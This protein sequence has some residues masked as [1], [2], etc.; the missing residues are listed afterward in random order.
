MKRGGW[1]CQKKKFFKGCLGSPSVVEESHGHWGGGGGVVAGR[2]R[3][4]AHFGV[5]EIKGELKRLSAPGRCQ[6]AAVGIGG[7]EGRGRLGQWPGVPQGPCLGFR[8]CPRHPHTAP[9]LQ[10]ESPLHEGYSLTT[11]V[12][13]RLLP[14]LGDDMVS[15]LPPRRLRRRRRRLP[16]FLGPSVTGLGPR[17]S[18]ARGRAGSSVEVATPPRS[19]RVQSAAAAAP[20]PGEHRALSGRVGVGTPRRPARV[21]PLRL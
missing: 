11:S 5:L 19:C 16:S 18:G 10:P 3:K 17:L 4:N 14:G 13:I 8:G 12:S 20:R 6:G 2:A 21:A 9:H 7:R 15:P 1:S